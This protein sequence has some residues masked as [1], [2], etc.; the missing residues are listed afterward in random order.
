MNDTYIRFREN[1][2]KSGMIASGDRVLLSMSA[3]KDSISLF[4]LIELLKKDISFETAVFHLN[5][6]TRGSDSDY[7]EKYI[8]HLTEKH[9]ITFHSMKYNFTSNSCKGLSFEENARN[10]RYSMIEQ[11]CRTYGYDKTATAHNLNDRTETVLMRILS[12]TGI[13][14]LRGI[15]T[16][17]GKIIRPMLIF[18]AEEI[19][20]Y[21]KEND[22]N[23]REDESNNDEKYLRNFIRKTVFPVIL[24][25]FKDAVTNINRLADH[26][27]ENEKLLS[28]LVFEKYK[29]CWIIDQKSLKIFTDRI[30]QDEALIKF[31]LSRLIY[32]IFGL[33][34]SYAVITEILRNYRSLKSN[35]TIYN[36]SIITIEKKTY[37]NEKI[38]LV[39]E[40]KY[41]NKPLNDWEY[42]VNIESSDSIYIDEIKNTLY[43][44][45]VDIKSFSQKM[46]NK[47]KVYISLPENCSI[48]IIRNRRDGDRILLENGSKK[49]KDLLIEKKLDTFSK[50][51]VPILQINNSIAAF[52]PGFAGLQGNRVS[53]E[54]KVNNISEKIIAIYSSGTGFSENI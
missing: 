47:D 25:R 51:I 2:I 50:S 11:I 31:I 17:T 49:I 20:S 32:Q 8:H 7:D 36:N 29:G 54:F 21:L 34:L 1:I 37:N 33:K 53:R 30:P 22:I 45:R 13:R 3:G 27:V 10:V 15:D 39:Y 26:A 52:L 44:E 23:W 40:T 43:F 24:P 38:L 9:G 12:G 41:K 16:D 46:F 14:G 4:Y 42:S 19:Y 35:N 18:T 28:N 6:L 48:I 5:H